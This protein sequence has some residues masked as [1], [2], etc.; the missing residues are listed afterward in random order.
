MTKRTAVFQLM[1]M[2]I[3]I[4]MTTPMIAITVY[5]RFR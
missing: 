5:C 2:P 3:T 1:K 4:A